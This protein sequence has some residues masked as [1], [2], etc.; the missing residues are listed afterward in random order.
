MRACADRG[1]RFCAARE[2]GEPAVGRRRDAALGL[3][4]AALLA[5]EIVDSPSLALLAAT[6]HTPLRAYEHLAARC[7][8]D[9][10]D[11]SQLTIVQLDEYVDV[12]V[13]DRRSLLGWTER[14]LIR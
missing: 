11:T 9:A 10:L 14:A 3:R 4:A 7:R 8:Q 12:D 6:G 2:R 5:Q 13:D 1:A